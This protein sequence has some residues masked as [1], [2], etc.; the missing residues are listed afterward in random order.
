MS[1][2]QQAV[3]I[4]KMASKN[5]DFRYLYTDPNLAKA[6]ARKIDVGEVNPF[7]YELANAVESAR[8]M[9]GPDASVTQIV[10]AVS[11]FDFN[12]SDINQMAR[13]A[14]VDADEYLQQRIKTYMRGY[15]HGGK[16]GGIRELTRGD[17]AANAERT[18]DELMIDRNRE[19]ENTG[20]HKPCKKELYT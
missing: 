7:P 4:Q 6:Q 9:L 2:A 8:K 16:R 19:R 14:G 3:E 18:L 1:N 11:R 20:V 17:R 15:Q 10:S 12:R 5:K 13:E